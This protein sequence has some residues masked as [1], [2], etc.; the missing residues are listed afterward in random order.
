MKPTPQ[1]I[2]AGVLVLMA[3]WLTLPRLLSWPRSYDT[4]RQELRM[5]PP[6][7][8][9]VTDAV[10]VFGPVIDGA[11][12]DRRINPFTLREEV[13]VHRVRIGEPP[14]PPLVLPDMPAMPFRERGGEP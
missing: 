2:V 10:T 11:D 1:M 12:A 3:A 9:A 13:L 14:P 6:D 7:D 4:S 5:V 8:T